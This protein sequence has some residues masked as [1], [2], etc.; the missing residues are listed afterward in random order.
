MSILFSKACQYAL[1]SI[2]YLAAQ[3]PRTPVLQRDIS[4][5]L[6]IPPHFL[7]KILQLLTRHEILVSHKGKSGGFLLKR[8]PEEISLLKVAQIVDGDSFLDHCILGFPGCA[9]DTP[10]PLHPQWSAA[11]KTIMEMLKRRHVGELGDEIQSKLDFIK[12]M[13]ESA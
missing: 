9:D 11:K 7:G 1:Q 10:C 12:L 6:N 5:A 2:I 8:S 13:E 4:K 3:P